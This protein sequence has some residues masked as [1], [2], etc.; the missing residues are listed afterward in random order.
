MKDIKLFYW[1]VRQL[2]G[3]DFL[4][5]I[6]GLASF[7]L[8]VGSWADWL[9]HE[10]SSKSKHAKSVPTSRWAA[11]YVN[12]LVEFFQMLGVPHTQLDLTKPFEMVFK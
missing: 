5:N 10:A 7:A 8:A 1:V 11:Q 4:E 3:R 2:I 12:H 9:G 6:P